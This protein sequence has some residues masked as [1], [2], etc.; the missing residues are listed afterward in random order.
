MKKIVKLL[1]INLILIPN[2]VLA[3]GDSDD[4]VS[5]KCIDEGTC[6]ELCRYNNTKVTNTINGPQKGSTRT[7][8]IIYT[9][10]GDWAVTWQGW[11]TDP[12]VYKEEAKSLKKLLEI[13]GVND[14]TGLKED[15]FTCPNYGYIDTDGFASGNEICFDNDGKSCENANNFATNFG[16]SISEKKYDFA[17]DLDNYF[18]NWSFGDIKCSEFADGTYKSADDIVDKIEKDLVKNYLRNN[19]MPEFVKN[20]ESYKNIVNKVT[21]SFN[22][23]KEHCLGNPDNLT[24]EEQIKV[25][26]SLEKIE[27]ELP[28]KIEEAANNSFGAQLTS[29]P[30]LK[31]QTCESLL[32]DPEI[33]GTPAF[34]LV[35]VFKV[36]KYV[37]LVILLVMSVMD[38]VGAVASHD[39]DTLKKAVSKLIM[40]AILC[41]IIFILPTIVEFV[42][43]FLS[44][45][46]ID[47]CGIGN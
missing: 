23:Q 41:V 8:S 6:I 32:G 40:R 39:N 1:I 16:N 30:A 19:I 34:Y 31:P 9:F 15:T 11:E 13:S 29:G 21:K 44:E 18:S 37:A 17:K 7:I 47:T 3:S 24:D 38:F 46:A 36:L 28:E 2:L 26:E 27:E 5:D 14:K 33:E 42:L 25:E 12:F 22:E 35:I 45:E 20:T 4:L 10:K 43:Q